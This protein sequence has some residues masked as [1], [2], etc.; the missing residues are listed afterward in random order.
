M[1]RIGVKFI[2][3]KFTQFN[4]FNLFQKFISKT[5]FTYNRINILNSIKFFPTVNK[6]FEL[7]NLKTGNSLIHYQK[8]EMRSMQTKRKL[9]FTDGTYKMKTKNAARKRFRI[10][11]KVFDKGFRHWPNNKR[12]KL[13]NKSRNNLKRKKSEK[14]VSKS[15]IRHLKR[16]FPYFKRKKYRN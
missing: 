16:L 9:K 3:N 12:H 13:I 5:F 10:V 1:F 14:Y 2:P 4:Q 8:K 6:K 7:P 15:D 11:G